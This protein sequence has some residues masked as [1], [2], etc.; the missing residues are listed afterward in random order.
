MNR[1][2]SEDDT[3]LPWGMSQEIRDRLLKRVY[4][5]M[6]REGWPRFQMLLIVIMTGSAGFLTSWYLLKAGIFNM[7][8][9]YGVSVIAG[10]IA[11]LFLIWLWMMIHGRDYHRDISNKGEESLPNTKDEHDF[12][13]DLGAELVDPSIVADEGC[14]VVVLLFGLLIA[15]VWTVFNIITIAPVLMT[16]VVVDGV[17][18]TIIYRQ[19]R[20]SGPENWLIPVFKRTYKYVCII[21]ILFT[22]CGW[23]FSVIYP[24]AHTIGDVLRAWR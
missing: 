21:L 24:K 15:V 16:E 7:G 1:I 4:S 12:P 3:T 11:F 19:I 18:M 20:K 10:Y 17:L 13:V 5:R 22:L 2:A 14:F 8:I 23:L 6:R 9:R